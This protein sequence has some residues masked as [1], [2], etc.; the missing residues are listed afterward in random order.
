MRSI[1]RMSSLSRSNWRRRQR[2]DPFV[3]AARRDGYRSR[4]VYKLQEMNDK[5]RFLAGKRHHQH[6]RPLNVL[7][8]GSAPG[9]WLQFLV[10]MKLRGGGGEAAAAAGGGGK[11]RRRGEPTPR[12]EVVG[13]DYDHGNKEE[14]EGILDEG[15]DAIDSVPSPYSSPYSSCTRPTPPPLSPPLGLVVGCDL[16]P[17]SPIP[18]ARF[19]KG[20]FTQ[21]STLQ[22]ILAA[23]QGH[24]ID[25]VLSDAAP[26]HMGIKSGDA[27]RNAELCCTVVRVAKTVNAHTV[28]FKTFD[29]EG[30]E[31]AP[32]L[33]RRLGF[34]SIKR[35][36]PSSS[37]KESAEVFVLC[38]REGMRGSGG[39]SREKR[40][41]RRKRAT[42][43]RREKKGNEE[44]EEEE[45]RR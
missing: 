20:D 45:R 18:G 38:R 3:A 36:K 1:R 11:R 32:S 40:R 31:E 23:F 43:T 4:A 37:R 9:S 39:G 7:D 22:R 14:E 10:D 12:R 41:R 8:L 19:V 29:G 6:H 21:A 25:I 2:S 26:Q 13:E 24:P 42:R 5:H 33:A 44:E 27:M 30:A 17:V 35:L 16:L 34:T 28:L 15:D